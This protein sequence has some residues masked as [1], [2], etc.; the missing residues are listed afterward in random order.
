MINNRNVLGT[1]LWDSLEEMAT[2][3]LALVQGVSLYCYGVDFNKNVSEVFDAQG[4]I[5]AA[6]DYSPPMEQPPAPED[7]SSP[8][9]G[10]ARCT[11]KNPPWPIIITAFII[12]QTADGSTVTPS[13]NREDGIFMRS[14]GI[15]FI[16]MTHLENLSISS[17]VALFL[18]LLKLLFK[19]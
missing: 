16:Y 1:L 6:Y 9:S 17:L 2:R 8:S 13:L 19:L 5:A 15:E 12:L 18:L 10:P 7:S 14:S 11:T 3:P 4:T